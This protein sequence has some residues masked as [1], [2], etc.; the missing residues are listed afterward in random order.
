MC[1]RLEPFYLANVILHIK[2]VKTIKRFPF[3]SK[4][5]LEATLILKT[6]PPSLS[7]SSREIL[8]LFPTINTIFVESMANIDGSDGLPDTVTSIILQAFFPEDL[9]KEQ[10]K[11]LD[12]IVD[13]QGIWPDDAHHVDV[14]VLPRLER[15][16]FLNVYN[17]FTLPTHKLK[18]LTVCRLDDSSDNPLSLFPP[19][20]A[21]QI[22]FIF[23]EPKAFREVKRK[24]L[25]ENVRI[26][27][28]EFDEGV[29]PED[30]FFPWG[31]RGFLSLKNNFGVDD[32]RA[33]NE[34][35]PF[36]FGR[37]DLSLEI[38]C[39]ACDISFL[40]TVKRLSVQK[41][42]CESLT[43]P[44][45]VV[46]LYINDATRVVTVSGTENL[47]FLSVRDGS[48][49]TAPCPKLRALEWHGERL[50]DETLPFPGAESTTLFLMDI[51]VKKVDST[52]RFP[53]MLKSISLWVVV[54][55]IEP[56]LLAPLTHLI[57]LNINVKNDDPLDL[58]RLTALKRLFAEWSPVS[59]LPMSLVRCDI[60]LQSDFDLSPLTNLTSLEVSMEPD[61]RVTFPTGLKE[62][63]INKGELT[64]T[65][66]GN[67]ALESFKSRWPSR[68][69]RAELERLPKTLKKVDGQFEPESL[70]NR[71]PEFFPLLE[72]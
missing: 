55:T 53:L 39:A 54:E 68:I 29:A 17:N 48:V 37:V 13:I 63:S 67:V 40:T 11:L 66:V 30:F 6:N 49:T 36:P 41:P 23:S 58:S 1:I 5:C 70:K 10:R 61:V 25:P 35:L 28:D 38:E 7:D 69:T 65:N 8:T 22:F 26:L 27:C 62:L 12:R 14:S 31:G 15:L 64:N 34:T 47:T 4:G 71:L 16:T 72:Q 33:F 56:S 50:S 44:T 59:H 24:Q 57:S 9:T 43:L 51:K 3:V 46:H 19:D 32:L 20:C 42:Q 45:S 52:F 60:T 21:E 2:R 18:R